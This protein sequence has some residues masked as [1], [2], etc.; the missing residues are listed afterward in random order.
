MDKLCIV[1]GVRIG[2][3]H[4]IPSSE[5]YHPSHIDQN[6]ISELKMI[7]MTYL[8]PSTPVISSL[9]FST[10]PLPQKEPTAY[11]WLEQIDIAIIKPLI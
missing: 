11:K 1:Y 4:Q 7:L 2:A 5:F 10:H 6:L 9:P 8:G 3:G